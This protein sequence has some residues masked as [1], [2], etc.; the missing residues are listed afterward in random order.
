[1]KILSACNLSLGGAL[2]LVLTGC[3]TPS[4]LPR[5]ESHP[6]YEDAIRCAPVFTRDALETISRLE[7]QHAK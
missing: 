2:L 5:L 6:D 1:M 3:N 4:N 7:N